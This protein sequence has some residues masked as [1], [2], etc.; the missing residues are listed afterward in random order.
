M[1]SAR[2]DMKDA[3]LHSALRFNCRNT[4]SRCRDAARRVFTVYDV[5]ETQCIASL[6][7]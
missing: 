6:H 2:N 5:V 3:T 4:M 1:F 7:L